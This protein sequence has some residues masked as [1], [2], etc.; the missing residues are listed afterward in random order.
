MYVEIHHIIPKCAGGD[1]TCDNLIKLTTREHY[2]A[3]WMLSKVGIGVYKYKLQFAFSMMA[4]HNKKSTKDRQLTARQ[5]ERAQ[6]C[7]ITALAAL[8][9]EAP[10]CKGKH[11]FRDEEGTYYRFHRDD[12]KIEFLNL[13]PSKSPGEGKR[14]YSDG[15]NFFMLLPSDE[16]IQLLNLFLDSPGK[17][18]K[19]KYS[20]ESLEKLKKDRVGRYWFNDGIRSYKLKATDPKISAN[21]LSPGR[22]ISE[23]GLLQIKDGASW[24]RTAADNLKNSERQLGKRRYT[25]GVKNF[26]LSPD[27]PLIDELQLTPGV[28]LSP[29]ARQSIKENSSR[30]DRSYIIGKKWFNDGI[31]NFRL[32]KEEGEAQSLNNGKL[33]RS[34]K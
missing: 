27:D 22:I 24:K 21:N 34:K 5:A 18:K 19:K 23:A 10:H 16:K 29:A 4:R 3:H 32:D 26:T 7:G 15:N 33:H 12:P 28:L 11:W 25:D 14:W 1:N 13:K 31:S 9:R 2:L 17:G 6:S 8:S 30:V 20:C